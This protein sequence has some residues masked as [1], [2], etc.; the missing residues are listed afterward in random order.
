[1]AV[2]VAPSNFYDEIALG[3]SAGEADAPSSWL[4]C[5]PKRS[6]LFDERNRFGDERGE[7]Q[8]Q[9][10]GTPKLVTAPRLL[11]DAALTARMRVAEK[12][13]APHEQT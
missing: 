8:L 2:G 6:A 13:I 4:Q 3:D 12:G 5:R 1:V 9:F 7:L 11:G 10:C